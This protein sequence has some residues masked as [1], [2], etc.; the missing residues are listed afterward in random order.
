MGVFTM[1]LMSV[2]K[3][4]YAFFLFVLFLAGCAGMGQP[5]DKISY[6]T[7]EYDFP[8]ISDLKPLPVVIRIERFSVAPV[9]NTNR[10]VYRD[11]SFQRNTY[12]YHRW[13]ANPAD[14]VTDY[15]SRDLRQSGLFRAV[16]LHDSRLPSSFLLEGAVDEFFE[17]DEEQGWR[18]MLTLS[19]TLM[20][21][22][23]PDVSKRVL[24]QRTYRS[25]ES[26]KKKTPAALA[27]AMSGAMGRLSQQILKD[28]YPYL[29]RR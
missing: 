12:A 16:L 9:Y 26:C 6:Y 2:H 25:S 11:Q 5:M 14:L 27:E 3:I 23:E 7:L 8:E 21:E 13:Q 17:L 29:Q 10:M 28:I 19:M 20:A 24:F 22:N 18:G 1:N 15:L 4:A